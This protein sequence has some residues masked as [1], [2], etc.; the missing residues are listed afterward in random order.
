MQQ[1]VQ[2]S[3]PQIVFGRPPVSYRLCIVRSSLTRQSRAGAGAGAVAVAVAG[4][5][6][7]SDPMSHSTPTIEP[8]SWVTLS[9]ALTSLPATHRDPIAH[10][11]RHAPPLGTL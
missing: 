3:L 9:T 4:E 11:R 10:R 7:E 1:R 8:L 2:F 6:C 5:C